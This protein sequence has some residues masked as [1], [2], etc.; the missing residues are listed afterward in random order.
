MEPMTRL[1]LTLA[2][3]HQLLLESGNLDEIAL[4]L[5]AKAE[6]FRETLLEGDLT[7]TQL[8]QFRHLF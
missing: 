2:R 7:I 1:L 4:N 6:K 3:G 8:I 5:F